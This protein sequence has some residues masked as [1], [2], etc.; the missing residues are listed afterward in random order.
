MRTLTAADR[1][2]PGSTPKPLFLHAL[3]RRAMLARLERLQHGRLFLVDA[4]DTYRFG[5]VS[6][7]CPIEVTVNV[8]DA[9]FYADIAF[10]GS[11]GAAR[12]I[13]RVIGTQAT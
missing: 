5:Q 13:C 3:A 12:R 7:L 8:H 10:G 6:D 11:V 9:R 4:D 1:I 2:A